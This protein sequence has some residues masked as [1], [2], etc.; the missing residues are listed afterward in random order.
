MTK[1]TSKGIFLGINYKDNIWAV[2]YVKQAVP[3]VKTIYAVLV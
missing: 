3:Y 1:T 2:P